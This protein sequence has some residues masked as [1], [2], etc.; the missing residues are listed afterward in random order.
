MLRESMSTRQIADWLTSG[1]ARV[2]YVSTVRPRASGVV[3]L[4]SRSATGLRV[5]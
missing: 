2:V 1:Q 4:R 3:S 5:S